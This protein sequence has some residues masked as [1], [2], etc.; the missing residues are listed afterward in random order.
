LSRAISISLIGKYPEQKEL[1][2]QRSPIIHFTEEAFLRE[3][4]FSRFRDK[5]LYYQI[6]R[7]DGHCFAR[8]RFTRLPMFP[9]EGEQHGSVKQKI[10]ENAPLTVEFYFLFSRNRFPAD[11]IEAILIDNK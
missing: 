5:G 1:Y 8:K 9:F 10:L 3:S 11:Q 2:I 7:N 4:P 6:K